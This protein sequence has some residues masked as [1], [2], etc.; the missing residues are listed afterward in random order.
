MGVRQCHGPAPTQSCPH[1]PCPLHLLQEVIVD[2][3]TG[4]VSLEVKVDV[5]V[6]AEAARVVIAVGLGVAEGLQDTVGLQQHILHPAQHSTARC[7]MA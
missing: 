5:H 3:A 6:L 7:A 4:G 2:V 1:T